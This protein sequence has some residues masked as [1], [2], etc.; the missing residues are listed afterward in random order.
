MVSVRLLAASVHCSR[1]TAT[2]SIRP[3]FGLPVEGLQSSIGHRPTPNQVKKMGELLEAME[4]VERYFKE[5]Q[6]KPGTKGE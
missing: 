5:H 3:A 2:I 6:I 4:H 1:P